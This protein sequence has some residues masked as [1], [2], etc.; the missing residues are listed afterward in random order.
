M[1]RN[2]IGAGIAAPT[3]G[4]VVVAASLGLAGWSVAAGAAT[5]TGSTHAAAGGPSGVPATVTRPW[6]GQALARR[7]ATLSRLTTMAKTSPALSSAVRATLVAQLAAETS[8][9]DALAAAAPQEPTATLATTA[10]AIVDQYRVYRVMAP[11]V[12]IAVRAGRQTRAEQRV[13]RLETALSARIASARQ[14]GRTVARAQAAEADLVRQVAQATA[15]TSAAGS[16]LSLQPSAYPASAAT[17]VGARA[18]LRSARSV[19]PAVRTDL[20]TIRT[21]LRAS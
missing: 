21:S 6:L 7:Q 16:V 10:A 17:I 4:V 2:R 14:S 5:P 1:R 13:S 18:D 15:D 20:R 3:I 8:G 19:L 11:K 12:R 9:I